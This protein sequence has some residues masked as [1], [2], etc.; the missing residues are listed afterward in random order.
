MCYKFVVKFPDPEFAAKGCEE[1]RKVFPNLEVCLSSNVNLEINK[2]GINKGFAGKKLLEK[3]NVD[4]EK[5]LVLGDGQNDI[6]ALKLTKHSFVPGYTSDE[7]KKAANHVIE[8]VNVVNFASTVISQ[9]VL[10]KGK[11]GKQ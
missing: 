4:P 1:L 10:K 3:I 2:K 5:I 8:G 7:V 9:Y 11:T 6:P